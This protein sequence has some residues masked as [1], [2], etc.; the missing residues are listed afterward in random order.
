MEVLTKD[1]VL[2]AGFIVT[3]QPN[4]T[5]KV[6]IRGLGPSLVNQGVGPGLVLTDPLLEL[7]GPAGYRR[8]LGVPTEG[9]ERSLFAI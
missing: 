6:M 2:I 9:F 5:K 1:N 3:G 7:H 8:K 4:T